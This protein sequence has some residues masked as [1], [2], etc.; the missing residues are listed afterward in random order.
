MVATYSGV[1]ERVGLRGR[2]RL[3]AA[4]LRHFSEGIPWHRVVGAGG[5]IKLTGREAAEQK[6]L[7]R[8]EGIKF[9][10]ERVLMPSHE[11]ITDSTG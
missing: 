9:R 10:G 2:A 8:S 7:L 6:A 3:V 4:V 11:F 5:H 1:A